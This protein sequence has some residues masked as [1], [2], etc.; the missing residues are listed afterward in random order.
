MLLIIYI[1]TLLF[2]TKLIHQA[3]LIFEVLHPGCVAIF[4]FDQSTNHNAIAED[5]LIATR[6][7]LGSGGVQPKMRDSWYT[8]EHEKKH[9]QSMTFP[10]NHSVERLRGQPKGIKKILE[11]RNL[12]PKNKINLVCKK[13]FKKYADNDNDEIRLHCCARRIMSLQSDFLEQWSALKEAV[14]RSGHI[15]ERYL[16]F[17]CECNF[18]EQYWAL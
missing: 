14:I 11:E 15:L 8:N 3:I 1:L 10:D 12:W 6:M 16:K 9:I 2:I 5:A 18:I 17:H 13:C 7:N 4:C